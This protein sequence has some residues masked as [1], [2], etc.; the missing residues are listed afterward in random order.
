VAPP[1]FPSLCSGPRCIAFQGL[2][3]PNSRISLW[4]CK[5]HV[6]SLVRGCVPPPCCMFCAVHN[7]AHFFTCAHLLCASTGKLFQVRIHAVCIN[8]HTFSLV[9]ACLFASRGQPLLAARA[10]SCEH[11]MGE[12]FCLLTGC[13]PRFQP[14]LA[15]MLSRTTMMQLLAAARPQSLLHSFE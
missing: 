3:Q 2:G 15:A 1:W 6:G 4:G 8:G 11:S 13:V 7:R 10:L 9:N 5:L 14:L 12:S